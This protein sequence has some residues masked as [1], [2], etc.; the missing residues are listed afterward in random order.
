MKICAKREDFNTWKAHSSVKID[1][2]ESI[3]TK[4]H[5]YQTPLS[6]R[7]NK[8][9]NN[10]QQNI[11]SL[12]LNF[13]FKRDKLVVSCSRTTIYCNGSNIPEFFF[14][15]LV[16]SLNY[17]RELFLVLFFWSFLQWKKCSRFLGCQKPIKIK[18]IKI[19]FKFFNLY[20]K[21]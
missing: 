2:I 16:F 20:Q 15:F 18:Q 21:I 8:M 12:M 9:Q 5:D 19:S 6:Y 13:N 7:S 1:K 14:F 4:H 11:I 10:I 17:L 3:N